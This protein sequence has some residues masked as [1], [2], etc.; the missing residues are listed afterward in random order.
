M[1]KIRYKTF[2]YTV[3]ISLFSFANVAAQQGTV[4]VNQDKQIDALLTI[5]KSVNASEANYKIQIYSGN[6]PGADKAQSEFRSAFREWSSTM[7]FETPNYK[8]WI[9][10]FNTRLEADRA[11]VKVK[12]KFAYAFY[13]KPKKD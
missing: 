3:S 1:I 8:I 12:L 10:N 2:I 7:E 5:K 9:G 11:L 4:E 13:F 6:R